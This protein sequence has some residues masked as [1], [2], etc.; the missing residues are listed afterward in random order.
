M[1]PA[2]LALLA[3]GGMAAA[4]AI[5][6]GRITRSGATDAGSGGTCYRLLPPP[7]HARPAAA[8]LF[9]L[10]RSSARAAPGPRLGRGSRPAAFGRAVLLSARR[11]SYHDYAGGAWAGAHAARLEHLYPG[12]RVQAHGE[13]PC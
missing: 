2:P 5:A 12:I 9:E 8:M 13:E 3:L 4:L 1:D 6:A 7:D 10:A 11:I